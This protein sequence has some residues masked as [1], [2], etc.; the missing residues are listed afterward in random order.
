MARWKLGT[1]HT[2][3]VQGNTWEY[4]EVDRATGKFVRK[5]WAVPRLL[6]P[7]DPADWTH[8]NGDDGYI[9]VCHPGKGEGNDI[10]FFKNG[11]FKEPG[12]PGPDM[13]PL[14]DEAKKISA[15][16]QWGA[17]GAPMP[18][19]AYTEG[20]M[21]G[22]HKQMAE[23]Q[24]QGGDVNKGIQDVLAAISAVVKQNADIIQMVLH[25]NEAPAPEA[26]AVARR[27]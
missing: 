4:K 11:T 18:D 21:E 5:S 15:S 27:G 6:D 20:L 9:V 14:D 16:Y 7:N 24:S 3:W 22:F 2:L 10:E 1:A 23:I 25:K 12:H 17:P 26:K 8:K 13:V 19:G